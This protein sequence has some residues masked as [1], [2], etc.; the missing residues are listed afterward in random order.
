MKQRKGKYPKRIPRARS[1]AA[2]DLAARVLDIEDDLVS[3]AQPGDFN[4]GMGDTATTTLEADVWTDLLTLARRAVGLK[5]PTRGGPK[6]CPKSC[7][8]CGE[9]GHHFGAGLCNDSD[10]SPNH[11]A[12]RAGVQTWVECKHCEAWVTLDGD[13]A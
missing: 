5:P 2:L 10:S 1:E 12:A 3:L 9:M 4:E 7:D 11:P 13:D 6:E 8:E